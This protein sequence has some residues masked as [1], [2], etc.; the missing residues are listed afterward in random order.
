[1]WI[2]L[3]LHQD[4]WETGPKINADVVTPSHGL[5]LTCSGENIC[6]VFDNNTQ[7]IL[8]TC[9]VLKCEKSLTWGGGHQCKLH[10]SLNLGPKLKIFC[11]VSRVS[12][13]T[14]FVSKQPKLELKLV[15]ALSETRCLFW[16]FH[17]NI[18]TRSF[19]VSK[20]PKQTKDQL[21]QQQIC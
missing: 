16:L 12:S 4:L 17:F 7:R 21:K 3:L 14:S 6:T 15:S 1:M 20:L 13:E 18:K 10:T 8:F 5:F 11:P 2:F 9:G 19:S